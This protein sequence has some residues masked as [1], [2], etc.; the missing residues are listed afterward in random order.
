MNKVESMLLEQ[1]QDEMFQ[2]TVSDNFEFVDSLIDQTDLDRIF[3][4][5]DI[6]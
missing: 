6:D 4:K 5:E 1:M 3:D 2:K